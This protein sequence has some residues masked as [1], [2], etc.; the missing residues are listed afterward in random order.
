MRNL[1]IF[2]PPKDVKEE[3]RI[4]DDLGHEYFDVMRK[5]SLM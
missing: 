2:P 4:I 1:Q 3:E 5:L